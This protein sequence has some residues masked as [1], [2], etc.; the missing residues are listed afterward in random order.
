[1]A[2]S[3]GS[4]SDYLSSL[5]TPTADVGGGG[6]ALGSILSQAGGLG[7]LG[8]L[9]SLFSSIGDLSQ[10]GVGNDISGATGL[11]GGALSAIP[12]I[13]SVLGPVISSIGSILGP[14]LQGLP[15][16]AKPEMFANYLQGQGGL[17][18]DLGN[19]INLAQQ[20]AGSGT[21]ILS[22]SGAGAFNPNFEA[23][24]LE[25]LTG[26]NLGNVDPT[27]GRATFTAPATGQVK[28]PVSLSFL[29]EQGLMS[30]PG[31]Q[32]LSAYGYT[33]QQLASPKAQQAIAAATNYGMVGTGQGLGTQKVAQYLPKVVA[34]L[35]AAGIEPGASTSG[36]GGSTGSG[37]G[38]G[39]GGNTLTIPGGQG[40]S[41]NIS[42]GNL[43]NILSQ[44]GMG[45]SSLG[46][47]LNQ[48]AGQ[49]GGNTLELP[50]SSLS[51]LLGG[52][53][54]TQNANPTMTQQANPTI[55]INQARNPLRF[56]QGYSNVGIADPQAGPRLSPLLNLT[57]V[58]G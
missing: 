44:L 24:L 9:G 12:G 2:S 21:G 22:Q 58:G 39:G 1:M 32:G 57:S 30:S 13:G 53:T 35:K 19:L 3:L 33:P 25:A 54:V 47:L 34:A 31:M 48:I 49:Q 8:G 56:A 11:V 55:N 27:T 40:G 20:H 14:M 26:Q 23:T 5:G 7:G 18:G 15:A 10:G 36:G 50:T 51:Q 52:S 38:G 29:G 16:N 46:Q 28:N 17:A 41:G 4:L 45:G 42:V 43:V 37:G 6:S